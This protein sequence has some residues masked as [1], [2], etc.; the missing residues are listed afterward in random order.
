MNRKAAI[1]T[2]ETILSSIG[3]YIPPAALTTKFTGDYSSKD[4]AATTAQWD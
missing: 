4:G 1:S 2:S 3:L